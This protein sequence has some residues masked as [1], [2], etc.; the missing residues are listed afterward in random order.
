MYAGRVAA[1]CDWLASAAAVVALLV[2]VAFP[3][4]GLSPFGMFAVGLLG[5]IAALIWGGAMTAAHKAVRAWN[6]EHGVIS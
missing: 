4:G 5:L 1:G 6:R 2:S 3:A